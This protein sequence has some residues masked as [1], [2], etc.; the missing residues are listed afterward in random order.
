VIVTQEDTELFCWDL[1]GRLATDVDGARP[2]KSSDLLTQ[3]FSVGS[4][5]KKT[6]NA[7][8]DISFNSSEL[9][10]LLPLVAS[11]SQMGDSVRCAS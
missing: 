1:L 2:G 8:G 7:C 11:V 9:S 4:V 3:T 6:C 10:W 5:G